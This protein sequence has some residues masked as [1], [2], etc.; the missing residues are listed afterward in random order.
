MH[1]FLGLLAIWAALKAVR[2]YT[3]PTFQGSCIQNTTREE[4]HALACSLIYTPPWTFNRAKVSL[5]P[6][7][8]KTLSKRPDDRKP[9]DF[10]W[11]CMK[12]PLFSQLAKEKN[13][14]Y[15]F[16]MSSWGTNPQTLPQK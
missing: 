8:F 3:L 13:V 5:F 11:D 1:V 12:I 2:F 7:I 4:L 10:C 15:I 9:V 14:N 16:Q 6:R